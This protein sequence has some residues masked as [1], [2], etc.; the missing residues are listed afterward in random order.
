MIQLYSATP[1]ERDVEHL[2]PELEDEVSAK[3]LQRFHGVMLESSKPVTV[4]ADGNCLYRA[5][6]AA[7]YGD[8]NYHEFTRAVTAIELVIHREFYDVSQN[9]Q[10]ASYM[11]QQSPYEKLVNDVTTLGAY[12][13]MSHLYAM[14]GALGVAIQSYMP[15]TTAISLVNP[16]TCMITG[17][18]VRTGSSPRFTLMW[19]STT[20]P[21][22]P[23]DFRPNHFVYLATRMQPIRLTIKD[24]PP[25]ENTEM[26]CDQQ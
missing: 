13:E 17:R 7:F 26:D 20:V 14:S 18:N 22:V 16:Y 25:K 5:A 6:A 10:M 12:A 9:Q 3:I 21:S 11:V 24:S 1:A 23:T 4:G 8:E 2:K 19:T 15:P